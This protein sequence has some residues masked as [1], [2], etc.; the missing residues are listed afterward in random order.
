MSSN[1][2]LSFIASKVSE[3]DKAMKAAADT[4]LDAFT[5]LLSSVENSLAEMLENIEK[6]GG[7]AAIQA[8]ADALKSMRPADFVVNVPEIKVSPVFNVP[9]A[10]MPELPALKL[11][12]ESVQALAMAMAG[13]AVNV[14]AVMP[15]GATPATT[16]NVPRIASWEM[17][18]KNPYGADRVMTITPNYKD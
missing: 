4:R 3:I 13:M 15:Q 16:I 9:K 12:P 2:D 11:A 1:G 10:E 6:G 5:N 18:I 8:M 14:E 17:R 7:A